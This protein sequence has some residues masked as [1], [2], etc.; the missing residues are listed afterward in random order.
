MDWTP[1][2][3][4]YRDQGAVGVKVRVEPPKGPKNSGIRELGASM[5][6]EEGKIY[7]AYS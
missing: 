5:T 7:G 3:G 2:G 4:G 6:R 1:L